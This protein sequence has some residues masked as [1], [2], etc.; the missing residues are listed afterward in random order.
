MPKGVALI[1]DDDG[2]LCWGLQ[3]ELALHGLDARLA[4]TGQECVNRMRE[5]RFDLLFL[6]LHLPDASGLD[7]L[8]SLRALSPSTRIVA[9]SS[10]GSAANKEA[11]LAAGAEQFLEKPFEI[12]VVGRL[13]SA[14]FSDSL[15]QRKHRRYLCNFP[16]LLSVLAPSPE[17]AQLY[18][19]S[20]RCTAEDVTE[21]GIRL[22]TDYPLRP[23]QGV[24]LRITGEPDP[25]GKM[26]PGDAIA[27]VVWAVPRGQQSTAGLRF[28]SSTPLSA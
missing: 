9:V 12:T 2:L 16:L 6:D 20:V 19:D 17:E 4:Q 18:L 11:A 1:A 7:L 21:G 15:C 27:K 5:Q 10:D 28:L 23:G 14:M 25:F 24:R 26:I 8:K 3:K 22:T 13:V